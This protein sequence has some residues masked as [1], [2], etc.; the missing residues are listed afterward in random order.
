MKRF[1]FYLIV[2]IMAL[3]LFSACHKDPIVL[4]QVNTTEVS[5]VWQNADGDVYVDIDNASNLSSRLFVGYAIGD[6][7]PNNWTE[8]INGNPL[9][10]FDILS[11]YV[12]TTVKFYTKLGAYEAD[13][14]KTHYKE[15]APS[16]AYSYYIK[17]IYD[18]NSEWYREKTTFMLTMS[19]DKILR[20]IPQS[21][22]YSS[23]YFCWSYISSDD[24]ELKFFDNIYYLNAA[25]LSIMLKSLLVNKTGDDDYFYYL[26]DMDVE[27]EYALV[28]G[29]NTSNI[30][31]HT[32][33]SLTGIIFE[34]ADSVQLRI[35]GNQD[36]CESIA[37]MT[38]NI[39][40]IIAYS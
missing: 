32:Y 9:I 35:K 16:I 30:V 36:Y 20:D 13:S 14:E 18:P 17:N 2:L 3:F 27:Y 38:I 19:N 8:Y 4:D 5:N 15:S 21:G 10:V 40:G 37:F 11:D 34:D 39:D 24:P 25:G 12:G 29:T 26:L 28:Y 31:W 6:Q 22:A 1:S 23:E 33:S 7:E